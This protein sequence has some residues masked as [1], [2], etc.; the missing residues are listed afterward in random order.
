M[1]D[2]ISAA[3]KEARAKLEEVR[4]AIGEVAP[5]AV[6][7]ISYR[8]P[9]YDYK[10]RLA[11]FGLQKS[12]IGLY[13]RPPVI[14]EHE[15]DLAGYKTTISA[16]H[17]PLDKEVPVA[18]VKKLVKARM[19]KNDAQASAKP[20]RNPLASERSERLSPLEFGT[21]EQT[22]FFEATP[23]EVYDALLD[24]KKHSEFTGSPAATNA[25]KG[26]TFTAWEGYISGKNLELVKGRRIVQDWR[27]T[28]F[29]DGYPFSRLELTLTAK[30]GG[31]ELEMVHS[32]VPADQ[33]AEYTG[34]WKS[35]YW[36]PLKDY[37]AQRNGARPPSVKR[38]AGRGAASEG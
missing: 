24:P 18:L 36:D 34:G 21:I 38:R 32:K 30:K 17:L 15:K 13:I 20:G 23:E 35:A 22:V 6:E 7:G 9:F 16:V 25:K 8:L 11:W 1:D 27:T 4:A 10:G 29:P 14:A 31:T 2:Y 3:P 19:M 26:A 33:V 28:E 12:H 37:F 5:T